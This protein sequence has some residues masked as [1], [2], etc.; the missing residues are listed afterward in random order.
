MTKKK[1][2]TIMLILVVEGPFV[3]I[4]GER[5]RLIYMQLLF[6]F[7][8]KYDCLSRCLRQLHI[9]CCRA[10]VISRLSVV[11]GVCVCM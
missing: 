2:G 10:S 1:T 5:A 7:G 9:A 8:S 11:Y 4:M 6:R 3:C